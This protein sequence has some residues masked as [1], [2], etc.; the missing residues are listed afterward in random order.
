MMDVEYLKV[1]Q[2][3]AHAARKAL[4]CALSE[5]SAVEA[6]HLYPMIAQAATLE[7]AIES[8]ALAVKADK[9]E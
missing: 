2:Q 6:L 4:F 3:A 1:A 7:S 9:P 8:L 5:S